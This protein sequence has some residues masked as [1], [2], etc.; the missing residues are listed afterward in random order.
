MQKQVI[1]SAKYGA[2]LVHFTHASNTIIYASNKEGRDHA[3]RNIQLSSE[4]RRRASF[5]F[6]KDVFFT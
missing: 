5:F 1:R 6:T 3:L 4:F 2:D